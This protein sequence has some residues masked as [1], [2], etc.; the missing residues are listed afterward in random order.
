MKAKELLM[1]IDSLKEKYP[2]Q[3]A[4]WYYRLM[5][6]TVLH[7]RKNKRALRRFLRNVERYGENYCK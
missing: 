1:L 2:V 7:P 3:W 6:S 4:K 5:K